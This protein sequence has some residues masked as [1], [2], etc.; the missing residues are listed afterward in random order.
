MAMSWLFSLRV[1]LLVSSL[2][3]A[4]GMNKQDGNKMTINELYGG[5]ILSPGYPDPYADDVSHFWNITMPDSFHVQLYFSDFDVE[6]SY[7]CEYDYVKVM[8]GDKLVGLFCGTEDTDTEKVPGDRVIE[9][10]GSQ[11]SLEFTSDFSNVDRHRG[12]MAHYRVVDRDECAVDNG[13][14][15]HFCHNYI[16]GY[17]CSCKAGY[18]IMKDRETCKFGCSRQVLTELSGTITTPEYPRMYPIVLDCD[19]KIQVEPGYVVTLQFDEGFDIEQHPEVSCPYDNLKIQAGDEKYGP[20]CGKT[21]PP[22]ITSTDHKMHVFFHSDDSGENKGFRATYFTTARPCEALSAPVY[23]TMEGSNFTYSQRVS[24]TCGEGYYL[25][26]PDSR[27]CQADGTWSGVQPTCKLVNCGALPNIS[28][29]AIEVDGNFSYSDIAIYRCDEFYEMVGEGTRFCEANGKWTGNEPSCKPICG[30][31]SFPSRDRIVGGGPSKKGAWPWQA[32][33]IH[34]GAPRIRKPFCGGALVDEKWILTA[35]HCVGENDIL[36]TGYLNVSLGLHNRKEPDDNVVFLEVKK[37]VRHPDWNKD[38]FD[39]DIA[40]LEL[41]EEVKLTDYIRPVCL[42]RKARERSAQ[43]VQEGRAGVVTGWGRTSNVFGS[44]PGTL[45]E[46]EVPVVDQEE[47]VSA[48]EGDYPVTGNMMCAGLR[49]GGK[50]SC[51]GDSGGPLLF[52]DPDTTRFYVA[53][54]VSWGQPGECG[55]ARKYGVYARVEN[56]VQWIKDTIAED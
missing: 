41:K 27:V 47:C 28:N 6:S 10:K 18:W 1:L 9:S 8:E 7:L 50:D 36:P 5:H 3:L 16:S 46:V 12:F 44:E 34:Q 54:I 45:Q 19:W 40:L 29:G 42:Q 13:G 33:V 49:V 38:T 15:H 17:Y 20:Y 21:V 37:V 25:D 23:G 52:Q 51:D 56:F 14:C 26:G 39:S 4:D 24:F 35:A 32:L 22:T 30:E 43:D 55:R 2:L 11:L 53:G 48:Y 31:S